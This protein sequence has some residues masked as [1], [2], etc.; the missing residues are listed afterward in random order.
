MYAKTLNITDIKDREIKTAIKYHYTPIRMAEIQKTECQLL[1][2]M[3]NKKKS[4][5]LLEM[6]Q[7]GTTTLEDCLVVCFEGKLS[8]T[9]HT[10]Q[11]SC[12]QLM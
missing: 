4:Y 11:Q 7:N 9:V 6:M 5:S 3:Q 2:K 1:A 10:I 12:T 8:F